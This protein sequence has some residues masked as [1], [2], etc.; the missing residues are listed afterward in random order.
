[1]KKEMAA[2]LLA[3]MLGFA[4]C[5][6]ETA[7]PAA[8]D[9]QAETRA[10]QTEMKTTG[11]A[12]AETAGAT[13]ETKH[14]NVQA[15]N[16]EGGAPAETAAAADAARISGSA[17]EAG[18]AVRA[19]EEKA[20]SRVLVAYFSWADNTVVRNEK[21]ALASAMAHYENMGDAVSQEADAVS[22]ASILPPGN[23]ARIAGWIAEETG[24]DLYPI[25]T[26]A[27][28][29]DD[30]N[31]T[32]DRAADEKAANARPAL[33]DALPDLSRYDT[34][35]IGYP[36]WWY[37]APMAV[38]SFI[39]AADLSGK[40]VVLF[41]THGTGG[42]AMSVRDIRAALPRDVRLSE[43]VLGV[44]RAEVPRA[45]GKVLA[46]LAEVGR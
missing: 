3:A 6:G 43:N 26:A 42:L 5:G 36:N 29:P 32:L 28:Y 17:P 14:L 7:K 12:A 4:G 8:G 16:A 2:L 1:M 22:S 9:A 44:Y 40:R 13:E 30:Y 23:A 46:W 37:T 27:P 41:C 20:E 15:A 38:F 31:D 39:D 10:V 33:A 18:G 21:A 11:T 24:G 35:F 19:A 45:K 25:R 34:V